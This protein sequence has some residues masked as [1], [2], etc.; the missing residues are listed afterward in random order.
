MYDL[1]YLAIN[2]LIVFQKKIRSDKHRE[3]LKLKKLYF[4]KKIKKL[5]LYDKE[6]LAIDILFRRTLLIKFLLRKSEK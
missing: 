5:N 1:E 4:N 2:F 3:I 6:Y